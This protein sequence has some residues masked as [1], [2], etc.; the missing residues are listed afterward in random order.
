MMK[1]WPTVIYFLVYRLDLASY[2]V[3][4]R[5][6]IASSCFPFDQSAECRN[7]DFTYQSFRPHVS[8]TYPRDA[9]KPS[10]VKSSSDSKSL[11][12]ISNLKKKSL[13]A[14]QPFVIEFFDFSGKTQEQIW[15]KISISQQNFL[16]RHSRHDHE[17]RKRVNNSICY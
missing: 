16:H 10:H 2:L 14:L 11:G 13:F 8:I 9:L 1:N 17:Q 3:I 7:R 4:S 15:N 6:D 12:R 5:S